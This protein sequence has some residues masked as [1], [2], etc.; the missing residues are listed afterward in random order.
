MGHLLVAVISV[1]GGNPYIVERVADN[2]GNSWKKAVSGVNGDNTDVEIWYTNSASSGTDEVD[3]SIKALPGATS[4]FV[5]TY[6]TV[7]EFNGAGRFHAGHAAS[8]SRTGMHASGPFVSTPGDLVIGGY[9][10]AGYIGKLAIIDNKSM[11]GT[12]FAGIDA[13]QGIQSYSV[14]GGASSSVG[15]SNNHF[16]RAEVA[17]ASF[18]AVSVGATMP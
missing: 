14:A 16:A 7:A 12:V 4:R 8:S 17:G 10:D 6:V 15:Y 18:T 11:L 5:Q 2:L 1:A 13:I 3:A 9:A